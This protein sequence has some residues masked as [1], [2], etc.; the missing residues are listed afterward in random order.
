MNHFIHFQGGG[1]I[2]DGFGAEVDADFAGVVG[3]DDTLYFF[4]IYTS[5]KTHYS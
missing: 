3:W 5:S 4:V 1:K 2:R